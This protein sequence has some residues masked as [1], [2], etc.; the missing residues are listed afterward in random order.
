M[1]SHNVKLCCLDS[2][3]SPRP[4]RI[5]KAD[6]KLI[7]TCTIL[8]MTEIKVKICVTFRSNISK[9][10]ASHNNYGQHKNIRFCEK[11]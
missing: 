9:E 10:N 6:R 2:P 8:D 11:L 7:G 1:T 4:M 3:V 5:V